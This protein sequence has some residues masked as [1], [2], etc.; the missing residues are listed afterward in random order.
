MTPHPP[1]TPAVPDKADFHLAAP[2]LPHPCS[3]CGG[4]LAGWALGLGI[5]SASPLWLPVK[6]PGRA[7]LAL[8]GAQAPS[9]ALIW[10]CPTPLY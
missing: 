5:P 7:P 10:T 6:G 4:G 1:A 3:L 2:R 8:K 9:H